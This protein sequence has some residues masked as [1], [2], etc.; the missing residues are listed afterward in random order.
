MKKAPTAVACLR[1]CA[2]PV[3]GRIFCRGARSADVV[4]LCA[5]AISIDMDPPTSDSLLTRAHP[6]DDVTISLMLIA[7]V[8]AV[9]LNVRL[10]AGD[11]LWRRPAAL[12]SFAQFKARPR[13]GVCR[14][15]MVAG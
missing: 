5:V 7:W 11:L 6:V 13:D 2:G 3:A 9:R 4:C 1:G 15:H 10:L 8:L 14:D 12:K